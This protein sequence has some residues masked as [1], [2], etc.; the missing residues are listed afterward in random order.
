[1]KRLSVRTRLTLVYGSLF[2]VTSAALVAV[3]YLL[4]VR[5][6]DDRFPSRQNV[7]ATTITR[8][9]A[10]A[11]G[12]DVSDLVRLKA[13]AD[14]E[15]ARQKHDVLEQLLQS[16]LVTMLVLG[17]LAV[18]IGYVVAGRMLR[19]LHTV[20]ATARRLSES[21]LYERIA[22]DGPQDEIKD[23]ADTFD[24][25]LDRLNRAFDAQRRFVAN[26]SH[27]LRTPLTINRTVLEVALAS[28]RSPPETRA[29]A[30][31]LLGNT[32]RHERLIEGL[33]LLARSERELATRVGTP[34]RDVVRSALD[35]LD[36]QVEEAGVDVEAR[37]GPAAVTGD[38][39][40]LERCAVN[41]LENAVKYNVGDGRVW[42]RTG[43][44]D[45]EAFLQVVNT[46]RPVPSYEVATIFEPFRRLRADRTGSRDGAGLGLSIVRAVVAAH[47]GAIDTVPRPDGGLSITVRLPVAAEPALAA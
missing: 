34:L 29:L 46:G 1:M 44:R 19:P 45:G 27:E 13:D 26:A 7:D 36:A 16:S 32:A 10:L 6:M 39:V 40:L 14:R 2:L 18:V 4:T 24:R 21:N 31:V 30:D 8:L 9:R 3:T 38:P 11:V 37:L 23:L 33:L 22:L 25:M 43:V 35:Q 41:L 5:T 12:G 42:V 15:L 28:R 47:G 17:V 20:T